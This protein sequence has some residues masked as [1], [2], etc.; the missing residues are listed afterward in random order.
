MAFSNIPRY[1]DSV[2]L[3]VLIVVS[4]LMLQERIIKKLHEVVNGRVHGCS[5][6]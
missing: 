4:A 2:S 5:G 1:L 6:G 3:R